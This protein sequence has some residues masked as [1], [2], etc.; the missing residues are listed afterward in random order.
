MHYNIAPN[1]ALFLLPQVP[2]EKGRLGLT[3]LSGAQQPPRRLFVG[4]GFRR[5]T[6]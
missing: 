2:Q 5:S 3:L 4:F 1:N 6:L